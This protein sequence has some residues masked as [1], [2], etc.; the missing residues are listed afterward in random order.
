MP[1]INMVTSEVVR[2][3]KRCWEC[4]GEHDPDSD[5]VQDRIKQILNDEGPIEI[6][7]IS[8]D[9]YRILKDHDPGSLRDHSADIASE[10]DEELDSVIVYQCPY[11][12]NIPN[13]PDVVFASDFDADYCDNCSSWHNE[14][15]KIVEDE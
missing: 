10:L 5:I 13:D 1:D 8:Y 6:L 4:K 9:R 15:D 11:C 3:G 2:D 12:G 7:G 14:G